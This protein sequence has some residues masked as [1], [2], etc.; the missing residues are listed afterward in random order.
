MIWRTWRGGCRTTWILSAFTEE[1]NPLYPWDGNADTH[2]GA[3]R[4]H[5]G[6]VSLAQGVLTPTATPPGAV[7]YRGGVEDPRGAVRPSCTDGPG[8]LELG[9]RGAGL[10]RA[11]PV[12]RAASRT[13]G[14]VPVQWAGSRSRPA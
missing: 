8:Y 3:A 13:S 11:A 5:A 1:W 6:Q 14:P 9:R 2:N 4:M 7:H 10:V 12:S